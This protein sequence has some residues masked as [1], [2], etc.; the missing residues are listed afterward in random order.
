[1]IHCLHFIAPRAAGNVKSFKSFG[2]HKFK[3]Q[4]KIFICKGFSNPNQEQIVM[5]FKFTKRLVLWM[6]DSTSFAKH[7]ILDDTKEGNGKHAICWNLNVEFS[8]MKWTAKPEISMTLKQWPGA[9][10]KEEREKTNSD[11]LIY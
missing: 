2:K 6:W 7:E 9:K 1:L 8:S 4:S 10:M 11:N 3:E 5:F